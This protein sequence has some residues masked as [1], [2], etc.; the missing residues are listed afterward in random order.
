M[1]MNGTLQ[2]LLSAVIAVMICT[3][4]TEKGFA[5]LRGATEH[6]ERELAHLPAPEE[7]LEKSEADAAYNIGVK[8]Y[9]DEEKRYDYIEYAVKWFRRAAKLGS[10]DGQYRLGVAYEWG[11]SIEIDYSEALKWYRLSAEQMNKGGQYGLGSLYANGRGVEQDYSEAAKWYKLSA[12]QGQHQAQY[13]LGLLY[14]EGKGIVQDYR[15]AYFWLALASK[16]FDEAMEKREDAANHL[17]DEQLKVI[18]SGL[19]EWKPGLSAVVSD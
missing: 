3:Y 16:K 15:R 7:I 12:I 4:S 11:E 8:Y 18:R 17:T 10:P 2:F 6:I 5:A 9:N 13:E 19:K 14:L 1:H